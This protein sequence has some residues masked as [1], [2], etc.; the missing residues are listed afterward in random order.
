LKVVLITAVHGRHVIVERMLRHHAK[1]AE[2]LKDCC[3]L[4]IVAAMSPE[5]APT[6]FPVCS[7]LGIISTACTNHPVSRK[8]QLAL[9]LA[10]HLLEPDAVIIL[11]SD[12]FANESYFRQA[13]NRIK[14]GSQG[15]GPDSVWF[16]SQPSGTMGLW[17]GPMRLST[18]VSATKDPANRAVTIQ[19]S[20][21]PAGA[22]R[23]LSRRL[24]DAIDWQLWNFDRDSAL[25]TYSSLAILNRVHMKLDIL[26]V[27]S[28]PGAAI[29]DVKNGDNMHDWRDLPFSHVVEPEPA[30]ELLRQLDLEVCAG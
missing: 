13:V 10:K 14:A 28:M 5:D 1:V 17:R 30:K 3:E 29:I 6:L 9:S 22:G 27:D 19:H 18:V 16:Y 20:D 25:D 2:Q 24:L 8:W 4:S 21:L 15:C 23:I 12:D 26:R 7:Q 11:G